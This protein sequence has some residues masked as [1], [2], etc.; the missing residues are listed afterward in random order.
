MSAGGFE[1][2][3]AEQPQ[4]GHEREVAGISR[5]PTRG[6]QGLE[7]QVGKPKSG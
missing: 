3:Q 1:D 5:L 6:Q 2:P 7:L 4:H